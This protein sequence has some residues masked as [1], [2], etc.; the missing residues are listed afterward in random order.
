MSSQR[1]GYLVFTPMCLKTGFY[2]HEDGL[3]PRLARWALR[4]AFARANVKRRVGALRGD[5]DKP[6]PCMLELLCLSRAASYGSSPGSSYTSSELGPAMTGSP[7]GRLCNSH[8]LTPTRRPAARRAAVDLDLL[9]RA[10][11]RRR[12]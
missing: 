11:E 4:V 1:T 7:G 8:T 2:V 6:R 9:Q 12:R 3:L 10:R 5:G